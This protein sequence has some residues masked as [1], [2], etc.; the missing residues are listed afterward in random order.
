MD[1]RPPVNQGDTENP[2]G[3]QAGMPD[4]S[5]P[6]LIPQFYPQPTTGQPGADILYLLK[7]FE[8]SRRYD[9]TRR[10]HEEQERRQQEQDRRNQEELRRQE[11]QARFTALIQTLI[12]QQ[13]SAGAPS[14]TDATGSQS[15]AASSDQ[16]SPPPPQ[17]AT[18]QTPPP[19][20]AD[21]TFQIFREWRRRWDDY[22]VMV[23]LSKLP[24]QKQ[25]IQMRMCLTL[26]TQ[27]VLEHTLQISPSTDMTVD[28][29]LNALQCHIKGLRNEALRRREL[30][31][32]KQLEGESFADFYVRLRNIAEEVDI[33]PGNSSTCEETQ[34]KMI[35]LMG[36]R[37]EE[38]TQRLISLDTTSSLRD[39]VATCRSYEAARSATSAIRAP[40]TQ[41]C[42]IS[43]Y[44]KDKK[45]RRLDKALQSQQHSTPATFCPSCA[46]QHGSEKC[47]AANST[48]GSCS[49]SGHWART[50]KCPAKSVQCRL[51]GHTGHYDKCCKA[52]KKGSRQSGAASDSGESAKSSKSRA[53]KTNS[54]RRIRSPSASSKTLKPICVL[55]SYEDNT[56]RLQMLPDTGADITVIGLRHLDDL[57]I[58]RSSLR[59][60]SA[61]MTVTADGSS[62]APS[63]GTFQ[64]TLTLGQKSCLARISVHEGVQTPLLSCAHCEELAIISP[65]F[66]KPILEVT[67]VNRCLELPISA[68][69]SPS[70]AK[71]YFLREFKDVLVSK[72]ELKSAPLKPMVGPPMRIHLKDGAVPFAIHTPRQIPFAF[73]S[74]VKEEL[75]SMVAQGIITPAGDDPSDWCH[76]LVVVAKNGTGVRITVDLSKL[77]NQVS[78]PAHPSPTPFAAIRS[79][80]PKAR[81]FTTADALC[82]YWQIELAEEDQ[83]LTTFITP[84]GR[85]KHC[86]GPM[87]FAATGDAYC[88]RG[89]RALQGVSNCVKVVDDILLY[90]EDYSAHL[91]RINEVLTRCRTYGITLNKDKFVVAA[92]AVNFCG[93]TLSEEGISADQEK[94]SAIRDFP[95]P[96]NLTDLRSFMGLVNQLAEFTPAISAEAQP[97]R[98]LMSP[99]RTFV[100][101]P[102]HDMA[103]QR[104]KQALVSPPVLASF[105]PD[106]PVILQT[107]ASRLYGVGYALLQDHGNN[108]LRLVQCGSR[109]LTDA[110]TRY[111]TI[112]LELLAVCWA[113]SKCRLYLIGLQ[114]FTLMTDHRPLIP[115]LNHY[116]LD[117]IEN[118][119]LQRLK[120]KISAFL[121]TAVWRAGKSLCIPDALSR[122]PVSRPTTDDELSSAHATT[123]LRTIVCMN[124]AT[125]TEES[126][127]QDA[128]RTLQELRDAAKADS[129]YVRLLECV[130]SGFPSNRYDLHNSLLPYWKLRDNLYADGELVLYGARVVVPAALRRRT[131]THLH[132]SHRGVE[133]TKRRAKQAVFWP[134]IDSDIKNTVQAC[135]SC[136]VLQPSQQQEP[137]LNDDTPTRPFESVSADFFTIAG[138]SF[139]VI[140]DRLSG[141]PVVIPCKG[142]TTASTTAR[143]FCRYFR[144]VG[145]PL[146]LRTD[147]GPQFT[148]TEF[149]DFMQ[150]WGVR[151]F[152]S[153]PHYPQSNGHAEAA[154]KSIKH[155]ILKTAPS[156]NID[157]EEFDRGLLEL[158]NTP[159]FTGRSPS[160]ILYGAP[161]RSCIPAHPT[162]FSKEWQAKTEDCDRRAAARAKDVKTRYDQHANPLP[163]LSIGQQVRI[164]DPIS[165]RWDKVGV[166]MGSGKSRDYEIRLPSGRVWWRN[167][168]FLR[169]VIPAS[170]EPS[171][172]FPVAP[173]SDQE[174]SLVNDPPI[175]PRRSQRLLENE[176]AR[177][178]TTSVRGEG[179]VGT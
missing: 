108:N 80:N 9:E 140:V 90:D 114:N 143:I 127:L 51:C 30:L 46:R 49:R 87:G 101:T 151:H 52:T 75:D 158:R 109:F 65:D 59:P 69:I 45:N 86:R 88:L 130:T 178:C 161:L 21:A 76:P 34:L 131:L 118:P 25:M 168:R 92:P 107:D 41:L 68:A 18:A 171:P 128:D 57:G 13:S 102:D 91:H 47:P 3:A 31:R 37:D 111:A 4:S 83:H 110:E 113:M 58:P 126:S 95:T 122:A 150:R 146:R 33:C 165:H 97:L 133:A 93:Y 19:L 163:R 148:S 42:A 172:P 44:K 132:D 43:A 145:V 105:N 23:D 79:V 24:R 162:S 137:L 40:P 149:R 78:R 173:C 96:A 167:R 85:F 56:S 175:I 135:E 115:I 50:V 32:C 16:P 134:G 166:V 28:E 14:P 5:P 138:K 100:W 61:T 94:V 63:L 2:E 10:Q 129:S 170:V 66:P 176:S 179:G 35:I 70:A 60:P 160:Q 11:D 123:H 8:E 169:P 54:C 117:A 139:L 22:A 103:F 12:Q 99:K 71:D 153:S 73:Q 64:A 154:V 26:E 142:D 89:D 104:V 152:L 156:G 67:H 144:E 48:C 84:Y 27:R 119:R 177:K 53:A 72:A 74:Q 121:F 1:F 29:V 155:L 147:G 124:A 136:Q 157:C 159:N 174:K 98:P 39:V 6:Q 38:L 62:M 125:A 55:L 116:S 15:T 7:Y 164:Q 77:N 106:L 20:K 36:V 141:W 82:G 112:E 17:K 81:Y 120:E